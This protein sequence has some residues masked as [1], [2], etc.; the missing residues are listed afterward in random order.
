MNESPGC[1][2][3]RGSRLR[4]ETAVTRTRGLNPETKR[5]NST[6]IK[7]P[8]YYGKA[9]RK[10]RV[11]EVATQGTDSAAAAASSVDYVLL[12]MFGG[13]GRLPPCRQLN[14]EAGRPRR[15]HGDRDERP[16]GSDVLSKQS[17]NVSPQR[18]DEERCPVGDAAVNITAPITWFQRPYCKT[19][20]VAMS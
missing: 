8:P 20:V 19:V 16:P 13:S 12:T 10:E 15:Y 4:H 5:S 11:A 2:W 9:E 6:C 3:C 18:S 1:Y 17:A 7:R 14:A